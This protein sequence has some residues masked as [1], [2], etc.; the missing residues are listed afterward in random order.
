MPSLSVDFA[1]QTQ[2][3]APTFAQGYVLYIKGKLR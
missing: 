1:L 3:E 2:L